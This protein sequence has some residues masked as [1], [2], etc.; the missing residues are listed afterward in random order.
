[1]GSGS[2]YVTC[3]LA[4][5]LRKAGHHAHC[6]AVD[7]SPPATDATRCTLAQHVVR[8][9]MSCHRP[10]CSAAPLVNIIAHFQV[11]SADVV[12]ADLVGP[13]GRRLHGCIDL[14]VCPSSPPVPLLTRR[15]G[16]HQAF[17]GCQVFNPPYVLTP[18]G[19]VSQSGIAAAWAGGARGR[20]VIDRLI[21]QVRSP[22]MVHGSELTLDSL[23]P[24]SLCA[25]PQVSALLSPAGTL[26]MV[27]IADNDPMDILAGLASYGLAGRRLLPVRPRPCT[28]HAV[29]VRRTVQAGRCCI[30]ARM[31]NGSISCSAGGAST[32]NR[33]GKVLTGKELCLRT[34]QLWEAAAEQ[35]L[36]T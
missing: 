8:I 20:A 25:R 10:I 24:A 7:V 29:D 11:T 16:H 5:L 2:G 22:N 19:E 30:G 15:V 35:G 23:V 26:L 32:Q 13:L 12:C 18:D 1:M 6:I 33:T 21:P 3:S 17:A 28:V 31:R 9:L 34:P 27:T 36:V 4:L 14:M